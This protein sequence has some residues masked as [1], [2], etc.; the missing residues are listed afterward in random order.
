M[1]RFTEVPAALDVRQNELTAEQA[2][3]AEENDL[4]VFDA[5]VA[6]G[7]TLVHH[8]F[9]GALLRVPSRLHGL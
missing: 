3:W 5:P 2:R 8:R 9:A 6:D 1:L 4:R 7:R